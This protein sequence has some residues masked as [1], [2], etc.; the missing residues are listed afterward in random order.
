[1][2]YINRNNTIP[3]DLIGWPDCGQDIPRIVHKDWT[4]QDQ[5]NWGVGTIRSRVWILVGAVGEFS[6]L[7]STF[8]AVYFKRYLF[9]YCVLA[10]AHKRSQSFC[11][12]AGGRLQLNNNMYAPYVC[13]FA[14]GGVTRCMVAWCTQNVPTAAVPCGTCHITIK[15]STVTCVTYK[16]ITS[17]DIKKTC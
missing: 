11:Q 3:G 7:G 1:M 10:V 13:G 17:V 9:H 16:Y 15:N 14:W 8:C 4:G 6:S 2:D 12:N 5:L